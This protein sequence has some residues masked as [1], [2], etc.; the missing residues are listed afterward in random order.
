M[1]LSILFPILFLAFDLASAQT[2]FQNVN[3]GAAVDTLATDG[4]DQSKDSQVNV[5]SAEIIMYGPIDHIFDGTLNVAGHNHDGEFH[6]ELHEGFI[7]SSKLI[8][9]SRF[10]VG[11]F[12]LNFGRLNNF[13]QH[14]WPFVSAPKVFREFLNPGK[15]VLEAESAADTGLEYSWLLPTARFIDIT[16]GVTNG[17]CFGE[18]ETAGSKPPYPLYY[19]H[20]STFVDY[21]DGKGLL[22]GA[23]FMSRKSAAGEKTDLFGID[24]TYK[25]REGK[26]LKWLVQTEVFY[27]I[28]TVTDDDSSKKFGFYVFPQYGVNDRL[29][30]GFRVDGFSY[31]NMRDSTTREK[32]RDFDY[33][34]VPTITYKSSEFSTVR[35]AYAHEVDTTQGRDNGMDRILQLQLTFLLGAHPSHEF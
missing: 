12:F 17:Y 19:I 35:L 1:R 11:K 31:L 10:R 21:G 25:A 15:S 30:L 23:S 26:R 20:P 7:G 22:L 28:Q 16:I 27:Q 9:E 34:L 33:A 32:L 5:R 29:S 8:P 2:N 13:H 6:F 3:I 4:F 14:D 18:C 24:A